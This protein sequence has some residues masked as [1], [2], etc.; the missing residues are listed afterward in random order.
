ML[1][2][3]SLVPSSPVYAHGCHKMQLERNK[4]VKM[5]LCYL[6]KHLELVEKS[7][8]CVKNLYV[9]F[10]DFKQGLNSNGRWERIASIK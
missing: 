10:P 1:E 8:L 2:Y 5:E 7:K 6:K 4:E 3:V 9:E